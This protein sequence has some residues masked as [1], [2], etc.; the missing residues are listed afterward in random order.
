MTHRQIASLTVAMLAAFAALPA[1]AAEPGGPASSADAY[2]LL[3]DGRLVQANVALQ[4][5]PVARAVQDFPSAAETPAETSVRR[6]GPAPSDGSVVKTAGV[7]TSVASATGAPN[8]MASAE[9]HDVAL[10]GATSPLVTADVVRA[11]ANSDCLADPNAT[12]TVFENLRVNGVPVDTTPAPNTV[13]DAGV[14]KV[15]LNEQRP[16]FD[17]RGIV[18]NG[19]HVLSTTSGDALFRGDVIVS[20]AVTTVNCPNG[21]GT[22]GESNDLAFE[23]AAD[24]EVADPGTEVTY[25]ARVTNSSPEPLLVTQLIDHMAPPLEFVSTSG[26]FGTEADRTAKRANGGTDVVVG[27]GTTIPAGE[28]FEQTFVGRVQGRAQPGVYYNNVELLSA[29]RGNYATGLDT[30]VRAVEALPEAAE[31]A[32]EDDSVAADR[33]AELPSTGAPLSLYAFCWSGLLALAWRIRSTTGT[34]SGSA[35]TRTE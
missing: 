2:G 21:A 13:I 25:T 32:G 20:H 12:G 11:Q 14:A 35:T 8:A 16:A 15:I 22:T 30:P 3:V 9:V 31:P 33:A 28:T 29:D 4:V 27:N 26:D 10:L 7:M 19:I 5:D 1:H 18:V 17:G 24:P 6:F 23:L 34:T